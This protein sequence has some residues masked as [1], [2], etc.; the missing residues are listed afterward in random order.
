MRRLIAMLCALALAGA[1]GLAVLVGFDGRVDERPVIAYPTTEEV[2]NF[3][4]MKRSLA[5]RAA[6]GDNPRL[7]F[8]SSELNAAPAG[9]AHPASLL[10][11]GRYGIDVM[12]CGRAFCSDLWQAIQVGA[13]APRMQQDKRAVIFVSMQWFMCY[14][15][16]ASDLKA[17]FSQG[18]YDAFM[19][20]ASISDDLKRR[21]TE[22]MAAYGVDRQDGG[23]AVSDTVRYLDD[24]ASSLLSTLKLA[25]RSALGQDSWSP[26]GTARGASGHAASAS[27]TAPDA[28]ASAS[29]SAGSSPAAAATPDWDAIFATAAKNARDKASNNDLGINSTWYTDNYRK[30]LDRTARWKRPADGYFSQQE[31]DDFEL[32]LE[33]CREAGVKPLIVIQPVKGALYDQTIYTADVR[34]EYYERV[35]QICAQAGVACADFSDHEYDTYFLREYSHPSDLGG[36]YYSK[37]IYT[38]FT[39]GEVDTSAPASFDTDTA[40]E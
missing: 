38:Y 32:L 3:D 25:A 13:L 33:V 8:G 30:W 35:R 29:G 11:G 20:N 34:R 7:V 18:A 6:Q 12:V 21:V 19:Q 40:G 10:E 2:S 14:R 16:P 22:R 1:V 4:L 31:F 26:V 15:T 27:R 9:G 39:T 36:A 28:G 24:H 37:A 17:S 23:N 5:A